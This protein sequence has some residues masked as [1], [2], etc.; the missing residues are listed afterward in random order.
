MS[1]GLS[2]SLMQQEER[3]GSVE[4]EEGW[5]E[6]KLLYLKILPP[7]SAKNFKYN[8]VFGWV[9]PYSLSHQVL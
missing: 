5:R 3:T 7:A 2:L 1:P 8:S 9:I 4:R 6:A